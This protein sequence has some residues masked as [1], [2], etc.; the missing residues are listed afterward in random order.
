VILHANP[1]ANSH[2]TFVISSFTNKSHFRDSSCKSTCKI[3]PHHLHLRKY[4]HIHLQIYHKQLTTNISFTFTFTFIFTIT[5]TSHNTFTHL[6]HMSIRQ[7]PPQQHLSSIK[8]TSTNHHLSPQLQS[9]QQN[10]KQ[11]KKP[12]LTKSSTQK[13]S[14]VFADK[15]SK[16]TTPSNYHINSLTTPSSTHQSSQ[17]TSSTTSF[18]T[19]QQSFRKTSQ[20]K[21]Q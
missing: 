13:P 14:N 3:T 6:L 11:L 16:I 15:T 21:Q 4:H 5:I 2:H 7:L 12:S 20:S 9:Q 18:T 19:T 10:D 8:D 1:H 17:K